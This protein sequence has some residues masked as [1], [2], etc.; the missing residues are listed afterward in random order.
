MLGGG[1]GGKHHSSMLI[2][3]LLIHLS[4]MT[5]HKNDRHACYHIILSTLLGLVFW[6]YCAVVCMLLPVYKLWGVCEDIRFDHALSH[7]P[8]HPQFNNCSLCSHHGIEKGHEICR[9]SV[10]DDSSFGIAVDMGVAMLF[11]LMY[12]AK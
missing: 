11:L 9:V 2:R 10:R 3:Q 4:E 5:H 7:H 12:T 8:N 1:R 6:H